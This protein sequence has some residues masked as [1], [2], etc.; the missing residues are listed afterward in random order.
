M[1]DTFVVLDLETTGLQPNRDRILEIGALKIKDGKVIET[2]STFVNPR[3][4]IPLRVVELTGI[5]QDMVESGCSNEEAI[6]RFLE[7]VEDYPL[8][9][10]NILFDYSFIKCGAVNLRMRFEKEGMDTLL[11]SRRLLPQLESRRLTALC[12]HFLIPH[13]HAHRALEDAKVTYMLYQKL[14]DQFYDQHKEAF[15]LR[16]LQY[17]VKKQSPITKFQKVHLNDLIKYHKIEFNVEIDSLTKSEA[18][19]AIDK[20]I[21]QHGRIKR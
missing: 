21:L 10:H 6:K 2:F 13:E 9:G 14:K 4:E 12:E 3:M 7:F 11:L 20:I 15:T 16:S 5:T 1:K 18:S 17:Q 8:L 19:R